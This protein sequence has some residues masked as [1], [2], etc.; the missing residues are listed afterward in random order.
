M[1]TLIAAVA[2]RS[3]IWSRLGDWLLRH[4]R[5]IRRTQWIVVVFYMVLLI[6][7]AILPLPGNADFI[8][9]NITR[10]AQFAF[11][12]IWWPFVLVSTAMVGRMW[13]G[14]LCPEGTVT[15]F[16]SRHGRGRAIPHW[17][18]W[19]GWPTL[20]FALTISRLP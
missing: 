2:P 12:G 17:V 3:D 14:I 19:A 9:S 15:E 5:T 1:T 6:A 4:Q 8:W 18:Q 16:V 7:P 11:W 20:A 10:F 13:C